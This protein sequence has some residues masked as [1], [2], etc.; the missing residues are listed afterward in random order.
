M[1]EQ[2]EVASLPPCDLCANGTLATYD[3]KTLMGPWAN[4]CQYHFD[5]R[6]I[7]LGTGKGQRLVVRDGDV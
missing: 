3:A 4:M 1:G 5:A 6:G 2:V 7:G